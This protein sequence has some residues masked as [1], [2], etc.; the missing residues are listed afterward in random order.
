MMHLPQDGGE[1]NT[2][3]GTQA[4]QLAV[5]Q[6]ARKTDPATAATNRVGTRKKQ[7]PHTQLFSLCPLL[8]LACT[9][10][11]LSF[12]HC[13]CAKAQHDTAIETASPNAEI[14]LSP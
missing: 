5:E 3:L 9:P 4:Y 11:L 6:G 1:K 10:A 13:S 14:P 12:F 7:D 8:L 2:I